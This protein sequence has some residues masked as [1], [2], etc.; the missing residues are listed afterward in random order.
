MTTFSHDR[1]A[2]DSS[3]PFAETPFGE[4]QTEWAIF[5]SGKIPFIT[6]H[7]VLEGQFAAFSSFEKRGSSLRAYR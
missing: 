7:T 3:E 1:E 4:R 5:I 6:F 2:A